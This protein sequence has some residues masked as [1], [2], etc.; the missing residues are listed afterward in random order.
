MDNGKPQ[1][2]YNYQLNERLTQHMHSS[3]ESILFLGTSLFSSRTFDKKFLHAYILVMKH[4]MVEKD[5][6]KVESVIDLL[7]LKDDE[8]VIEIDRKLIDD[9][10]LYP[11]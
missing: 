2:K 5:Y 8:P 4:F 7:L 10:N 3:Y 1:K 9:I 6:A 11:N